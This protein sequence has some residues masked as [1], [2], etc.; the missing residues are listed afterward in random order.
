M[1]GL[2]VDLEAVIAQALAGDR[3]DRGDHAPG[4]GGAHP[5]VEGAVARDLHDVLHLVGVGE[6]NDRHPPAGDHLE[7]RADRTEIERQRP[8]I[9]RHADHLGATLL[10]ALQELEVADA[11]FLHGDPAAANGL[12]YT[13]VA[14]A[15]HGADD[16][17]FCG[18]GALQSLACYN[19]LADDDQDPADNRLSRNGPRVV[20]Q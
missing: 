13:W 14:V 5:L 17:A 7:G 20:A 9:H 16:L 11:V 2:E 18:P 12:S 1:G 19:A 4:Q 3:P 10:E 8:A 15:D 6:Q